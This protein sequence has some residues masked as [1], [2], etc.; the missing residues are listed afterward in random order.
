MYSKYC[1]LLGTEKN[2]FRAL[3][4]TARATNMKIAIMAPSGYVNGN[5]YADLVIEGNPENIEQ[6]LVAVQ[7]FAE[8]EGMQP[9]AV[10]PLTEMTIAPGARIAQ[11]YNLNYLSEKA[12]T[13]TRNKFEMRKAAHAGGLNVPKFARFNHLEQLATLAED[14]PFPAVVKPTNA[15]GSEGVTYVA[16]KDDLA[17]A[18]ANLR[19]VTENYG[20][21]FGMADN[22]YQIEQFVDARIELSVEVLNTKTGRRV[23]AVTDKELTP[24]PHFV[25]I[26]HSLPS[27]ESDNEALKQAALKACE[28]L[29]VEHGIAHVEFMIDHSGKIYL[30]ELNARTPGGGIPEIFE[31][32]AGVNMLELHSRSYLYDEVEVPAYHMSGLAAIGFMKAKQG[33]I[34]RIKLPAQ[35]ELPK[36]AFGLQL[37]TSEGARVNPLYSNAELEGYVEFFWP[38]YELNGK[39]KEY[40]MLTQQLTEQIF[41]M[42]ES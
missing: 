36:E 25:E 41:E 6:A 38:D 32:I 2:R 11:Y 28:V 22:D 1:L 19:R 7:A 37:W 33:T 29:D 40:L 12:L 27:I 23:L 5:R 13:L 26:G 10:V 3:V 8:R 42:G 17:S 39:P 18:F 15:G 16:S 9:G 30:L 20:S 14:F 21:K 35:H 24:L 4:A 34:E 31:K